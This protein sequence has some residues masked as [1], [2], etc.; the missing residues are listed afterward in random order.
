[1]WYSGSAACHSPSAGRLSAAFDACGGLA[2]LPPG[3]RHGLGLARRARREHDQRA[4]LVVEQV[5]LP[6]GEMDG[7][8]FRVLPRPHDDAPPA[9]SRRRPGRRLVR[10][11]LNGRAARALPHARGPRPRA[12]LARE[13]GLHVANRLSHAASSMRHDRRTPRRRSSSIRR[14]CFS[15]GVSR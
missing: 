12:R 10:C 11:A 3:Q 9:A 14:A 8:L 1:M 4:R 13:V 5:R 7:L 6:L 15:A 2:E